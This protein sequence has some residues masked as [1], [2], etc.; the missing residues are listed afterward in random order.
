MDDFLTQQDISRQ[1]TR[2]ER[3]RLNRIGHWQKIRDDL[4]RK[5]READ[6]IL[7]DLR[8]HEGDAR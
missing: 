8:A 6:D 2:A 1:L 3:S 4:A 7:H 5:L